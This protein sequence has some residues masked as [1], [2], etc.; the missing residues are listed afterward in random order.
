MSRVQIGR[1]DVL[2]QFEIDEHG[3]LYYGD[4]RV[5]FEEDIEDLLSRISL[6]EQNSTPVSPPS[7]GTA[8]STDSNGVLLID[9]DRDSA[10]IS[11][12]VLSVDLD[13]D[14]MDLNINNELE[15]TVDE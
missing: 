10:E 11:G 4:K 1:P 8:W 6:L 5:L 2:S 7:Q 13:S 12:E 14:G 15:V 9:T 3:R